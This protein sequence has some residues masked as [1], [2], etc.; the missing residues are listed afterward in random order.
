MNSSNSFALNPDGD[1]LFVYCLDDTDTP[2][3]IIGM[4]WSEGGW[5]TDCGEDC[6]IEGSALPESLA[7]VGLVVEGSPNWRYAGPTL[8]EPTELKAAMA[9]TANWQ[10][11]TTRYDLTQYGGDGGA[12]SSGSMMLWPLWSA[13]SLASALAWL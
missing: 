2:N 8:A 5:R 6:G 12:G 10:G 7:D 1:N 11:S 9:D 13:F 3:F 4:T